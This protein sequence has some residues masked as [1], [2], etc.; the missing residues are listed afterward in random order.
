[1]SV[2]KWVRKT[3]TITNTS[4]Q[5]TQVGVKFGVFYYFTDK[6]VG[7]HRYEALRYIY[8]HMREKAPTAFQ[9]AVSFFNNVT[10]IQQHGA[11]SQGA[12]EK[13][14]HFMYLEK[15]YRIRKLYG[16]DGPVPG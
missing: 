2:G 8:A 11:M 15:A 3:R 10:E 7:Q 16:Q 5:S 12:G 6:D 4:L 1:M 9:I 14:H 13:V